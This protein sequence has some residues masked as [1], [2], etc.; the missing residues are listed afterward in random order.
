MKC[1]MLLLLAV[2]MMALPACRAA[3]PDGGV[4][5]GAAR[6]DAY[7]P[8]LKG[9]RV[10]LFSNQTGVVGDRHVLDVLLDNGVNV[11]TIFSPEHGFR[12]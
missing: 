11:V 3:A 5:V 12:G 9:K 8:L 10:A 7:L 1:R 4:V 2:L 6:T